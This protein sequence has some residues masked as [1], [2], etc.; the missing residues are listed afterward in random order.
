MPKADKTDTVQYALTGDNG[1]LQSMRHYYESRN[2]RTY[3]FRRTQLQK[4]KTALLQHEQQ[5]YDALYTDLKKNPE[6]AWVTEIG[7]VIAEINDA[8]KNLKL[9]MH[10]EQVRTNL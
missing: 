3:N 2:T 7:F 1:L 4:L 5:L 10:D 8:F 6:E 9:W